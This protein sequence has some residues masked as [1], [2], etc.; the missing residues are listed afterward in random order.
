MAKAKTTR[1]ASIPNPKVTPI[2]GPGQTLESKRR[3]PTSDLEREIRLRAY[4]LYA[5]RG[6]E[7]GHEDEDWLIAERE[8]LA[9]PESQQSA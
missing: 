6:Y 8:I 5:Q 9:R 4:E 1:N 2:S 3:Q 7:P